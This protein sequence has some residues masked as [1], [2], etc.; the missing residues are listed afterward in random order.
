MKH[1]SILTA[2]RIAEP[3]TASQQSVDAAPRTLF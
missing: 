3:F 1:F 2:K